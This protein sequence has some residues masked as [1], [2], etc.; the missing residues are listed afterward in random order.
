MARGPNANEPQTVAGSATGA[1]PADFA[2][3]FKSSFRSLWLIAFGVVQDAALAEDVVQEAALIAL[4]KFKEFRPGSNFSA[5]M[6]KIVQFVAR[7]QARSRRRRRTVDLDVAAA[8]A[9]PVTEPGSAGRNPGVMA[10]G[11]L[12]AE[13]QHFDDRVMAA[14]RQVPDM[15]RACLLLRT[16]EGL[17]Y[18]EIARVLRIPAGTA[19]SHVHRTRQFLREALA[20]LGPL[21]ASEGQAPT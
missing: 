18:S 14:L 4:S 5:W 9:S 15:P 12:S 20:E 3:L 7:N 19:M 10:V 13:Q 6:A 2:A 16:L 21:R 1:A 8:T 17:E 11:W